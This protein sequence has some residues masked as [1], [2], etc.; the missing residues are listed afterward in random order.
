[1]KYLVRLNDYRTHLYKVGDIPTEAS[2]VHSSANCGSA[3][4]S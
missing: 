4:P 3:L 1:M 2:R